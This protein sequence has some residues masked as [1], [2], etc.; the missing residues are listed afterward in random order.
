MVLIVAE[1]KVR[2]VENL[3]ARKH[4]GRA[5]KADRLEYQRVRQKSTIRTK[6]DRAAQHLG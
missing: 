4:A 1:S 5:E 3:L 2:T 6:K